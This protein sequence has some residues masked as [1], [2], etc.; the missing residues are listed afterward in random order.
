MNSPTPRK[1]RAPQDF[2]RPIKG[3]KRRS[4]GE[5]MILGGRGYGTLDELEKKLD[6][7]KPTNTNQSNQLPK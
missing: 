3:Q 6:Q 1:R 7:L 2:R 4:V 5:S